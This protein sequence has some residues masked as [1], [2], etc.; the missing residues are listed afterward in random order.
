MQAVKT[1]K[2]QEW[3]K[4]NIPQ[5][6]KD[7]A[8]VLYPDSLEDLIIRNYSEFS[9]LYDYSLSPQRPRL[10]GWPDKNSG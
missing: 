1:G 7:D 9:Q 10:A 4:E 2:A 3:L 5:A 6:V 8:L